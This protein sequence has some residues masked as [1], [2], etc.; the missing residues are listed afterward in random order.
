MIVMT[1]FVV[2]IVIR[3]RRYSRYCNY[4][5]FRRP[6]WRGYGCTVCNG[7]SDSGYRP[8]Y[9]HAKNNAQCNGF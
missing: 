2:T 3:Y 4:G 1:I 9:R 7:K 8:N 6:V 5:G